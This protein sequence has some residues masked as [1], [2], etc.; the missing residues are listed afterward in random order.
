MVWHM[1]EPIGREDIAYLFVAAREAARHV[2]LILTGFGFDGCLPDCPD[3]DCRCGSMCSA[4]SRPASRILRLHCAGGEP[5][6][7][8]GRA[9]KTLYFR[10][11]GFS[12]PSRQRR[13]RRLHR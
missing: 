6:G 4:G 3:I 9:L 7:L 2:D 12:R 13:R 1:E 5:R 8:G 10:G 11:D